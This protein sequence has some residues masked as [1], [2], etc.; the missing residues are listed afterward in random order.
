[1]GAQCGFG[2]YKGITDA[3]ESGSSAAKARAKQLGMLDPAGAVERMHMARKA[4][5]AQF[6]ANILPIIRDIQAAGHASLNAIAGQLNAREVGSI[7]RRSSAETQ[8]S[9][10]WYLKHVKPIVRRL[11]RQ[12]GK[13]GRA[14]MSRTKQNSKRKRR[15]K[16]VP[17][18]GA[19]GLS[20]AL[21]SEASLAS[22]SPPLDTMMRSAAVSHKISL[23]DEEVCDVS[24]ATFHVFDR[25]GGKPFA[26]G[27][28]RVTVGQGC[29][30]FACL[31]GQSDTSS[32]APPPPRRDAYSPPPRRPT[33]TVRRRR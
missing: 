13:S 9:R 25:E 2:K 32:G 14:T 28:R 12:K 7:K 31:A 29:C 19:A 3:L 22:T 10:S 24:L 11:K 20:L 26:A 6:A 21:A 27:E 23:R 15:S 16:A 33:H 18:L 5:E 30:L 8:L 1:V 4:Q 17:V